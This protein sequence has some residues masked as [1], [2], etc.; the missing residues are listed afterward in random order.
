MF[1]GRKTGKEM[2]NAKPEAT[3][4][5]FD[6]KASGSGKENPLRQQQQHQPQ[7]LQKESYR[8]EEE[9]QQQQ[10][11]PSQT[12]SQVVGR[13]RKKKNP[14]PS[15]TAAKPP[16]ADKI[17]LLRRRMPKSAAV[18][19][20]RPTDG[21]SMVE[22]MRKVSMCIN[23][24]SLDIRVLTTRRTKA[25]GILLEVEGSEKA[26]LLAEKIRAVTGD[27]A[28]TR[29]P[30][31]RTPVLLL[32]IPDWTEPEEILGALASAGVTSV[33]PEELTVRRNSGG[34]GE[35][36][37]S[38]PLPLRDAILLAEA[39]NVTIGW[40][41]CRVKLLDKNQPTCFRCQ[42]RGHLAAACEN[43]VRPR[44]C[45]KCQG[46]DHVAKECANLLQPRSRRQPKQQQRPQ[47]AANQPIEKQSSAE[48]PAV[49]SCVLP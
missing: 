41:R 12:W 1:P 20:D 48:A 8:Q 38:L 34:R 5:A 25:G 44:R 2:K 21:G 26:N 10:Q 4:D 42:Q 27:A 37:A 3:V 35:L 39:R 15:A 18:I 11:H 36:V 13:S 33:T 32:G 22:I 17:A 46:E 43:E 47:H 30:E 19:I 40:T 6:Q 31:S 24:S 29:L 23:L 9:R 16:V 14:P 45:Y 28:R 7:P 49:S